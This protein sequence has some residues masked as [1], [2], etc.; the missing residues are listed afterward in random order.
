ML[1]VLPSELS[2]LS[3][4]SEGSYLRGKDVLPEEITETTH[5]N[6]RSEWDSFGTENCA[7]KGAHGE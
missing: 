7:S 5:S 4:V 2:F 1:S 3:C 6:S